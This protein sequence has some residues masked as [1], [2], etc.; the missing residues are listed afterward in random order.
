MD[1]TILESEGIVSDI[2]T[3]EWFLMRRHRLQR[4]RQ[5]VGRAAF[6]D[7]QESETSGS[8]SPLQWSPQNEG[9][10]AVIPD[11]VDDGSINGNNDKEYTDE[12]MVSPGGEAAV[13]AA[14]AD[15]AVA[16]F[17]AAAVAVVSEHKKTGTKPRRRMPMRMAKKSLLPKEEEGSSDGPRHGGDKNVCPPPP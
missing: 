3:E 8:P 1:P 15:A 6:N 4:E 16:A 2:V 10:D 5:I 9:A 11:D 7:K 17:V 14:A 12:L 13:D